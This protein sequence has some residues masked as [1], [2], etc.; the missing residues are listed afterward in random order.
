MACMLL[1]L[2]SAMGAFVPCAVPVAANTVSAAANAGAPS[3]HAQAPCGEHAR[4]AQHVHAAHLAALPQA[5]D[6]A[7]QDAIADGDR[8]DGCNDCMNACHAAAMPAT[9]ASLAIGA[10]AATAAFPP[11]AAPA[12]DFPCGGQDRPPRNA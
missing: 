2:R 11:L 12:P 1:S 4:Q 8:A 3:V 9:A 5:T 7:S 10:L 6:E